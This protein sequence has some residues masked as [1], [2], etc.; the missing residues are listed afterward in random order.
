MN[1][2]PLPE[3]SLAP[4]N[5]MLL[6]LADLPDLGANFQPHISPGRFASAPLTYLRVKKLNLGGN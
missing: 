6:R 3:R 4:A 1:K 2:T 5:V